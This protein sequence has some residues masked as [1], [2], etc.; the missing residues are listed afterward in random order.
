MS[1]QGTLRITVKSEVDEAELLR[2][3]VDRKIRYLMQGG[4]SFG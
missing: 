3:E 4:V 2:H 1:L